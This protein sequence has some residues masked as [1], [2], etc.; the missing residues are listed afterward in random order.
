MTVPFLEPAWADRVRARIRE[1]T[2][3]HARST[4]ALIGRTPLIEL[5]KV[6]R[7]SR[8]RVLGKLEGLNPAGSVKDRLA[9][10]LIAD[11]MERGALGPGKTLVEASS[12]NT[13]IALAMICARLG[14]RL[15]ITVS[16]DVS[17]E[18]FKLMKQYGAEIVLTPGPRGTCGAIEKA[19]ELGA[20]PDHYWVAQHFNKVNSFAHY[21]TTGV[22]IIE[23]VRALTDQPLRAMVATSGT[24]GTLMGIS[25][26]LK[27]SFPDVEVVAVWPKDAI[28]GIRRPEGDKRPGIY[29]DERIDRVF[30]VHSSDA[31]AMKHQLATTEGLLLGPSGGAAVV[32]A[33]DAARRSEERGGVV[34]VLLPD[35][36]ER[37]LSLDMTTFA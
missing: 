2:T 25:S 10:Y 4:I 21:E 6:H 35:F 22:E 27:E 32:A 8:V 36:G 7:P 23:Q 33:L 3:E 15:V 29:E 18:R 19:R 37:Y 12:G 28:M 20:L 30:E 34:L 1:L 5:T 13:G 14:Q 11:A 31:N 26:R 9:L 24:T 16:A 17:V